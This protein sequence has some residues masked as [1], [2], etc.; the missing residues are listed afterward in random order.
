[1]VQEREF[2]YNGSEITEDVFSSIP[3]LE[4]L[5]TKVDAKGV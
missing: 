5:S 3:E 2:R 4:T 1:M